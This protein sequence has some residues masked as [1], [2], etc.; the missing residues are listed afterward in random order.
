[1]TGQRL[2]CLVLASAG[3]VGVVIGCVG[4]VPGG[5]DG[6]ADGGGGDSGSGGD[7]GQDTGPPADS[8][9]DTGVTD[10][11]N[12]CVLPDA[13]LPGTRDNSFMYNNITPP[14]APNFGPNAVTVGPQ[15]DIYVT[16]ALS[17]SNACANGMGFDIGLYAFAPTGLPNAA[18]N[19]NNAPVCLNFDNS[20]SGYAVAVDAKNR[21]VIGGLAAG[22]PSR[23]AVLARYTLNGAAVLDATFATAGK[24]D[25]ASKFAGFGNVYAIG[26]DANNR[27]YA[28]GST[29][30]QGDVLTKGYLVRIDESGTVDNTFKIE[31]ASVQGYFG[32]DVDANGVTVSGASTGGRFTFKRYNL[33]GALDMSFGTA[34]VATSGAA[35]DFN[36][37]MVRLSA[38]GFATIGARNPSSSGPVGV[39]VVQ[40]NGQPN[41]FFNGG[42]ATFPSLKFDMFWN[43]QGLGE[44]CNGSLLVAGRYDYP[45]AAQDMGMMRFKPDGTQ[46]TSFGAAGMFLS[47]KSG[48]DIVVGTAQDPVSKKILLMGRDGL[49]RL[50]MYRLHP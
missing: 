45:D 21:L 48:N 22:N 4:D 40:A 30:G 26:F 15:G 6:G 13:G 23:H 1:M 42:Q 10:S 11:G 12:P 31:D 7:A 43:V 2:L 8:G 25:M 47:N 28:A 49:G 38:G 5:A 34:G 29:G 33:S 20:D 14:T 46:D 36:R 19:P 44:L 9:S 16:G 27:L 37:G 41:S 18:I 3:V 39:A 50:Q 32:V 17:S 35:N 24:L